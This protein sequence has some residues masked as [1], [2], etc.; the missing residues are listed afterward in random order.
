MDGKKLFRNIVV[1]SYLLG[2][3]LCARADDPAEESVLNETETPKEKSLYN[4]REECARYNASSIKVRRTCWAILE[5]ELDEK[6]VKSFF[7]GDL[8]DVNAMI[9]GNTLL[10]HATHWGRLPVVQ[11]LLE[12]NADPNSQGWDDPTTFSPVS[13]SSTRPLCEATRKG[14]YEIAKL[15]LKYKADPN[16]KS[17]SPLPLA[18]AT[19]LAC[20]KKKEVGLA[21]MKLL[22]KHGADPDG[23]FCDENSPLH[24]AAS[25][26]GGSEVIDMLIDAGANIEG[27]S[28]GNTP[29]HK[30]AVKGNYYQVKLLIGKGASVNALN[31]FRQTSLDLAIA[32]R[33]ELKREMNEEY[34][35]NPVMKNKIKYKYERTIEFLRK[36]GATVGSDS[37]I[38]DKEIEQARKMIE[39]CAR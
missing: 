8:K 25:Y 22:L 5:E 29:L 13:A 30:A 1:A 36:H 16:K 3:F 6:R 24:T 39:R 32:R 28:G 38:E 18:E 35:L 9:L 19:R 27:W 23:G 31:P 17:A 20:G 37:E 34:C 11:W 10:Y 14:H 4:G 12:N 7:R 26:G 21:L 2:H 15:L 33:N